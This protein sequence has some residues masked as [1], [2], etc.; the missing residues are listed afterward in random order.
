MNL[1]VLGIDTSCYTTSCALV[2]VKTQQ[3]HQIREMLPVA[4]GKRGLRQSEA[5]FEHVRK[6]PDLYQN[7]LAL[8]PDARIAAVCASHKP[9]DFQDSYMPVFQAGV[10]F[11]KAVASTLSV[12]LYLTTHQRG[13]IAAA[14]I[15]HHPIPGDFLALH[16]SGGTTQLLHVAS[17]AIS[18]LGETADISA[19]QLID[20]I[21]VALGSSFPAGPVVESWA[22]NRKASGRYPAICKGK[23]LHFSGTEAAAMRDIASGMDQGEIAAELF[24]AIV[25]SVLKLL[26]AVR[27]STADLPLLITGGVA[28]SQ[29]FQEMIKT[30]AKKRRISTPLIFSQTQYAGDNAAGVAMNG[31]EQYNKEVQHG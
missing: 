28:S 5:V 29:L 22:F 31:L 26:S 13:H 18:V 30:R 19:G 10:S 9:L 15:G 21:G 25:R 7:L 17:N 14:L 3:V 8:A 11:A 1:F 4:K 24:D 12:P 6:L 20:R 23:Y 16:L 2:D 27:Q